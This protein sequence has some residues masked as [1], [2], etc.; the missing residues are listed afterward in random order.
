MM[1]RFSRDGT[2]YE[3]L[4]TF[5]LVPENADIMTI[6]PD[7]RAVVPVRASGQNRLMVVQKG[8]DPEPL[9]NTA[10]ERWRL[11]PRAD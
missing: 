2:S 5:P 3:R 6:L 7:G 11:W 8:E 9:V 10:E 1:A 4:A